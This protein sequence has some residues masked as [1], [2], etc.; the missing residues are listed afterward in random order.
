MLDSIKT[1]E[2]CYH[3]AHFNVLLMSVDIFVI[4][5]KFSWIFEFIQDGISLNDLSNHSNSSHGSWSP[6]SLNSTPLN[7]REYN[8]GKTR[9]F[10]D[11][12]VSHFNTD[13][14]LK[15]ENSEEVLFE[16]YKERNRIKS[17]GLLLCNSVF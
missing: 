7:T 15:L 3:V 17:G 6:R 16:M 11:E 12:L 14:Y 4:V 5:V 1:R 2:I 8:G 13:E 10:G 9:Q